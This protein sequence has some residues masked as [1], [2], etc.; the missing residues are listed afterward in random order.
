MAATAIWR[1]G[2]DAHVVTLDRSQSTRAAPALA[3]DRKKRSVIFVENAQRLWHTPV[4]EELERLISFAYGAMVPLFVEFRAGPAEAPGKA[5]GSVR[6]A[7]SRRIADA[8]SKAPLAWLAPETRS[9]FS[10]VADAA[11]GIKPAEKTLPKGQ[12]PSSERTLPWDH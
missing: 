10:S 7:L 4:A 9:K 1:F 8:K 12:K 5:G 11:P 2:L 3:T 6:S